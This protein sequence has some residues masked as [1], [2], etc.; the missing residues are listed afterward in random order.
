MPEPSRGQ[1]PGGSRPNAI[2]TVALGK[3]LGVVGGGDGEL[4]ITNDGG[5]TWRVPDG[6]QERIDGEL[7]NRVPNWFRGAAVVG[8]THAWVV[9]DGG[10]VVSTADAGKTFDVHRV[11]GNDFFIKVRFADTQHGWI[12]GWHNAYRTEDGGKTWKMQPH[13]GGV[14]MHGLSVLDANTAWIAGHYGCIQHTTDGGKTWQTLNDYTDLY[15]VEMVD[16][17]VGYAG[18]DSGAILKTT[19][20]G[21]T[22]A[23]LDV[24]RGSAIE[25]MQFLDENTGWAVGDFGHV[26]CT[27]DGGTSWRRGE[28]DFNDILKDLHFF[29]A[30]RGIAVGARGAVF[31]TNDGGATWRRTDTPTDKMLYGVDFPTPTTGYASGVGVILKTTDGGS[32]WKQLASPS[33]EILS[34]VRFVN[35]S[36]GVVVGDIGQIFTTLDGGETWRQPDCPTRECL[37]RIEVIDDKTFLVAGS[38]GTI[39]RS[40][41]GGTTWTPT[42][43]GARN[44]VYCIS[45]NV[46]VGRWGQVQIMN[47]NALR[48]PAVAAKAPDIPEYESVILPRGVSG[49]PPGAAD[50]SFKVD[51]K[52]RLTEVTVNGRTYP[53][54]KQFPTFTVLVMKDGKPAEIKELSPKDKAWKITR[55]DN[56]ASNLPDTERAYIYDSDLLSVRVSYTALPDR[57]VARVEVLEEREGRLLKVSTGDGQFIRL[58]GDTP[59]LVRK[60]AL[61]VPVD[62]GELIPFTGF[63]IDKNVLQK[64]NSIG[65]WTFKNRMITFSDGTA[66]LVLR[67]H[68]WHGKFHYGQDVLKGAIGPVRFLYM[69]WSFDTRCGSAGSIAEA[70]ENNEYGENPPAWLTDELPIDTFGFDL[71]YVGDVNG[72][73]TANWVDAVITYRDGNYKRTRMIDESPGMCDNYPQA[74]TCFMLWDNPF[75]GNTHSDSRALRRAPDGRPSYKWGAWSR[76]IAYEY[77]SGRLARFFD[78]IADDFD[79]E[80]LPVHLGTDTWTCAGGGADFSPDHPSTK[81]EAI[82]AKIDTLQLLAR[83]GYRTDSEALSE[84]GLAG[85]LLWGWWTPY[86]GNGVWPGGFSRSWGHLPTKKGLDGPV[87]SHIFAK[88]I[89]LQAVSF[90]GITYHGAGSRT[91]PGYAIMHGS[92][93]NPSGMGHLK[94][95][96]FLY[97][98]WI[99]LWKVISPHRITNVRD[100]DD[101]LW[102]FTYEDGSVLK[103]DVRA[104]T[105]VLNKDGIV[106]DG[107]SPVNPSEDPI[108]SPDYW[109]MPFENF[110]PP[111]SAGSFGVWRNGTFTIKV[112]GVK[113]VKPPRVAG[114]PEKDQAPPEY[115]TKYSN[116]V[117]TIRIENKDPVKHPM[118]VFQAEDTPK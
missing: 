109:G 32:T 23:F 86:V 93:P 17:Q 62:G 2:S 14:F 38:R 73:D 3:T 21:R 64:T 100:L 111:F 9:G 39:L 63:N 88:S 71:Q 22:W 84:W 46:A 31:S 53:T 60:G 104:N 4:L 95:K 96:E 106:Y 116:G 54:S 75:I 59:E 56:A 90:Q 18:A 51:R 12:L 77:E 105:W 5:K 82:R 1:K 55:V 30:K 103:L 57:L 44:N 49:V 74:P 99:V 68:Q 87:V 118:L 35:E 41:D 61:A 7:V 108:K 89:P 42:K 19:D 52:G 28:I 115:S 72:D 66:G 78:K 27:T 48:A 24:P 117:L 16:D 92:R 85:N 58:I 37:H 43:A 112:P 70:L 8:D 26:I 79:F 50:G 114:A 15:A 36:D 91:P 65:G 97:Y 107:Y 76:S 94:Y 11:P 110:K 40:T 98:P 69:G 101:D 47:P 29:D 34:D 25:A 6:W 113:S 13:A 67:S 80:P 33:I 45:R 10:I 20:G 81:E 83:R 102:Q